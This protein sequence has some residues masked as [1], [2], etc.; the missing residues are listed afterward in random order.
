MRALASIST[1]SDNS[2]GRLELS[3]LVLFIQRVQFSSLSC[4]CRACRSTSQSRRTSS[5]ERSTTLCCTIWHHVH[6][7]IGVMVRSVLVYVSGCSTMGWNPSSHAHRTDRTVTEKNYQF[8]ALGSTFCFS[9]TLCEF[10]NVLTRGTRLQALA[11]CTLICGCWF[12]TS[13]GSMRK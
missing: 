8:L 12:H 1:A 9:M 4:S 13:T 3:A 11:D 10:R 7:R 5:P 6:Q 2:C